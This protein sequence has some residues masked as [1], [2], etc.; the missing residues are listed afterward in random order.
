MASAAND[1]A[2]KEG[3]QHRG[4]HSTVAKRT[5]KE[6]FGYEETYASTRRK[7]EGPSDDVTIT[8]T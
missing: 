7:R 4:D 2:K 6:V 8:T 3:V 5:L 1:S